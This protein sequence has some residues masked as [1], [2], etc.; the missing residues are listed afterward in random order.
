MELRRAKR[1]KTGGTRRGWKRL[2]RRSRIYLPVVILLG[3]LMVLFLP[4]S[5]GWLSRLVERRLREAT[6]LPLSIEGVRVQIARAAADV[7]GLVLAPSG[8]EETPFRIEEIRLSGQMGDLLAGDGGW[9][10]DILV[11]TP[12]ELRVRQTPEGME[13]VGELAALIRAIKLA[14]RKAKGKSATAGGLPGA[15]AGPT[16]SLSVRNVR[17]VA[18]PHDPSLPPLVLAIRRATISGRAGKGEPLQVAFSGLGILGT[19]EELEGSVTILEDGGRAQLQGRLGGIEAPFSIPGLGDFDVSARDIRYV[20]SAAREKEEEILLTA[21]IEAGHFEL[22]EKRVGG[23]RWQEEKLTVRARG[24]LDPDSWKL[25]KAE[26]GLKGR[27]VDV[28]VQGGVALTG[29]LE[30]DVRAQ[31]LELPASALSLGQRLARGEG[32]DVDRLTSSTLRAD[33]MARGSFIRPEELDFDGSIELRGWSLM[34]ERLPEPVLLHELRCEVTPRE[35]DVPELRLSSAG[36]DAEIALTCP[37]PPD[38]ATTTTGRLS[39]AIEG[40]PERALEAL[41]RFGVL[42]RAINDLTAPLALD[43]RGEFVITREGSSF[44]GR[45]L[46]PGVPF[47]GT[48]SW[49]KGDLALADLPRPVRLESGTIA[50]SESSAELRHFRANYG[51]LSLDLDGKLATDE[52]GWQGA[53]SFTIHVMAGGPIPAMVELAG[54]RA[55]VPSI[56]EQ[57]HGE[58]RTD[59]RAWGSLNQPGGIQYEAGV[60]LRDVE[61][62]IRLPYSEIHAGNVNAALTMTRDALTV[63]R[64]SMRLEDAATVNASASCTSDTIVVKFEADSPL[65]VAER[66]SPRDLEELAVDG[67]AKAEGTISLKPREPLDPAP[68]VVVAWARALG[69]PDRRKIGVLED[70]PLRLKLD[71]R[72]KPGPGASLFHRDFPHPITDI[73]GDVT[74]DETGFYLRNVLSTW[75]EAKD[76]KVNGYVRL[77]HLGP[78]TI[79]FDAEAPELN[80]NDWLDDWGEAEW[81]ERPFIAPRPPRPG[82]EQLVLIEGAVHL[83]KSRFLSVRGQNVAGTLRYEAWRG[84]ENTLDVQGLQAEVYGGR[85]Q[86]NARIAFPKDGHLSRLTARAKAQDVQMQGF[87]T[88]LRER[89]EDFVGKFSGD[90]SI[91]GELG[92]YATWVGDGNF[93]VRD[94]KFI[95]EQA[96]RRLSAALNL[97]RQQQESPT[98]ISGAALIRDLQV[99]FPDM[100]VESNAIRMI[101]DG[102]VD[103]SGNLDFLVTVNILSPRVETLPLLG[104]AT[105]MLDRLTNFL[106]TMKLAGTIQEPEVQTVPLSLDSAGFFGKEAANPIRTAKDAMK[107]GEG[108]LGRGLRFA[109]ESKRKSGAEPADGAPEDAEAKEGQP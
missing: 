29:A 37:L 23:E 78:L 41:K 71:A 62:A 106:V 87:L 97:G 107:A 19:A 17:V 3:L 10:A 52:S 13:P 38:D 49:G 88:D 77:G 61:T 48:V 35:F 11:L 80:L 70:S 92:D 24:A 109:T 84:A 20:L 6:G 69:G 68:N 44:Q 18:E 50:F 59:I 30:G 58:A 63:N 76:V 83:G 81:A 1:W 53:P 101:A 73:R 60:T 100:R 43:L 14:P 31:V 4:L 102:M 79:T 91:T 27:E 85:I 93:V 21:D 57:L 74:A 8:F 66:V 9:P 15:L 36:F 55:P 103:F 2:Y 7:H 90:A 96:F 47:S 51:E 22:G 40:E 28:R 104:L 105:E 94:S 54:A 64:L 46:D 108:V 16:P 34:H 39:L 98:T 86:G 42:P 82:P 12:S 45:G 95:G 89:P 67:S 25:S 56:V 32:F 99:R 75:G 5:P 33:W 72:L 65:W 26:A